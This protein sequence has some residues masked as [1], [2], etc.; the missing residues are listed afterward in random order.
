VPPDNM[1]DM[2]S[3]VLSDLIGKTV[4]IWTINGGAEYRDT[5]DVEAADATCIQ[6]NSADQT[7][8]YPL[9]NVRLIKVIE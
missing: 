1:K 2:E 5:G 9:T 3:K 4:T 8:V 6:L 7:L